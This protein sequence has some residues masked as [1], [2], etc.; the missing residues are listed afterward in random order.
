V[1]SQAAWPEIE[2]SEGGQGGQGLVLPETELLDPAAHS[3]QSADPDA[4][5]YIPTPQM[6]H[7]P[8]SGPE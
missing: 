5:L 1:Y 3:E 7:G 8:P 6:V 4:V 2:Y